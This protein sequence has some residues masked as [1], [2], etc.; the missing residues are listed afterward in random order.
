MWTPFAPCIPNK[1]PQ[2]FVVYIFH[3]EPVHLSRSLILYV[4]FHWRCHY[5]IGSIWAKGRMLLNTRP[6]HSNRLLFYH[7]NYG[8]A[9]KFAAACENTSSTWWCDIN[10]SDKLTDTI[11]SFWDLRVAELIRTTS[12]CN[13]W[14]SSY[15][16]WETWPICEVFSIWLI[17]V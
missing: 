15:T 5:L 6:T 2:W 17:V 16:T 10:I 12:A 14:S 7:Y 8:V 1:S 11:I 4:I 3:F 13:R 9:S